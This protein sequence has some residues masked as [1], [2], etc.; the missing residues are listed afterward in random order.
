MFLYGYE[1]LYMQ[2]QDEIKGLRWLTKSAAAEHGLALFHCGLLV[3]RKKIS[4]PHTETTA[5]DLFEAAMNH[6][7]LLIE[8]YLLL[9]KRFGD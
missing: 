7:S 5:D 8:W 6:V 3:E 4:V 2:K 9:T 1:Y